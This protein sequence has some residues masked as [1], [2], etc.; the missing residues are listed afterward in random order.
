MSIGVSHELHRLFCGRIKAQR[1]I[2]PVGFFEGYL[3][4]RSINRARRGQK[5]ML[6]FHLARQLQHVPGSGEIGI[7]IR[8][9]ILQSVTDAGLGGEM[10]NHLRL[11]TVSGPLQCFLVLQHA[12]ER[13]ERIRLAKNG[14]ARF[15]Q[16]HVIVRSD[17]IETGHQVTFGQKAA[18]KVETD[19]PRAARDE[20]PHC[21]PL[22]CGRQGSLPRRLSFIK[23]S[24]R[25]K[26]SVGEEERLG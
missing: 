4:I 24:G 18:D 20:N 5:E 13:G 9:G 1:L 25:Q 11:C 15:F 14:V 8:F 3:F 12:V 7:N 10:K 23:C 21:F 19:E 26:T 22:K 17:A 6:G 2:G 16:R